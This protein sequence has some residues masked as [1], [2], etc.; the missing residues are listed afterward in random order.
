[1]DTFNPKR[2]VNKNQSSSNTA[3]ATGQHPKPYLA[4]VLLLA[5]VEGRGTALYT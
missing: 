4:A 3:N 1:M 5:S 2:K